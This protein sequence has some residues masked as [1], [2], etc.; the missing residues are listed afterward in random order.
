MQKQTETGNKS[1]IAIRS[2]GD[3]NTLF[4]AGKIWSKQMSGAVARILIILKRAHGQ[5]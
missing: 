1:N 5:G 4:F 3:R 2:L